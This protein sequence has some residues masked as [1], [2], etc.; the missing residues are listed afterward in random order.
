LRF[1]QINPFLFAV[2]ALNN[3]CNQKSSYFFLFIVSLPCIK[4]T[5]ENMYRSVIALLAIALLIAVTL[6]VCCPTRRRCAR[7]NDQPDLSYLFPQDGE[8]DENE[9]EPPQP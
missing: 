7:A 1:V 3:S 6:V 9:G 5:Q 4:N 8:A 2:A